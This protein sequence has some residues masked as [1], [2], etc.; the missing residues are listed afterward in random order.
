MTEQAGDAATRPA[1]LSDR[2]F[3]YNELLTEVAGR[4]GA[5]PPHRARLL[6]RSVLAA[7]AAQLDGEQ[8]AMLAHALPASLADVVLSTQRAARPDP[9]QLIDTVTSGSTDT[10][11]ERARYGIQ[12]VLSA[13]T[14]LDPELGALLKDR[15]PA[16]YAELFVAPGDGPPPDRG[17][18]AA[19]NVATELSDADVAAVLRTLPGWR[20]DRHGLFRTVGL[21]PGL[22]EPVLARVQAAER[23]LNHRAVTDRSASDVTFRV[24][25]HSV[26]VVTELDVRLAQRISAAIEE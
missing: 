2:N 24:W 19:E 26:G 22:D 14:D 18:T 21:P 23:E 1:A 8:R 3:G 12:A 6:T 15:L 13:L 5:D 20:G 10:T 4:V 17:A 25:T 16:E 7:L 11:A 9:I